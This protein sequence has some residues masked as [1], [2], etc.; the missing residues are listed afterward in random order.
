MRH[1]RCETHF[2][3]GR[4]VRD[5]WLIPCCKTQDFKPRTVIV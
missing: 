4:A 5:L 1:S 3:T 2:T